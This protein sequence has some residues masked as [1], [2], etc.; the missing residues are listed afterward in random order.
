MFKMSFPITALFA[1]FLSATGAQSYTPDVTAAHD[2]LSDGGWAR[3]ELEQRGIDVDSLEGLFAANATELTQRGADLIRQQIE[4]DTEFCSAVRRSFRVSCIADRFDTLARS[5][6]R[7]GDYGNIRQGLRTTARNLDGIADRY[8]NPG[9]RKRRFSGGGMSTGALTEVRPDL[10]PTAGAAAARAIDELQ[11]VLLRSAQGAR[12]RRI[13]FQEI[14][15][16]VD[17]SKVLLRSA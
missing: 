9:A 8:A 15:T 3:N 6:P 16:T 11:T 1:A 4:R 14:A 10:V 13:L 12:E 7:G 17:E 5:L 2:G